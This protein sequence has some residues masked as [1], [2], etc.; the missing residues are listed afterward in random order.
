MIGKQALIL[1]FVLHIGIYWDVAKFFAAGN[2]TFIYSFT[3]S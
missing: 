2:K 3:P 1:G